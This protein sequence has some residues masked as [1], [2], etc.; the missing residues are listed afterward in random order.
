MGAAQARVSHIK[1][2]SLRMNLIKYAYEPGE[3]YVLAYC[4]KAMSNLFCGVD[5]ARRFGTRVR[6]VFPFI[7]VQY[8][9]VSQVRVSDIIPRYWFVPLGLPE[10]VPLLVSY[11]FG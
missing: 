2:Q 11:V 8:T 1:L 10:L 5:Q 4:A 7:K 9:E 3:L 6:D